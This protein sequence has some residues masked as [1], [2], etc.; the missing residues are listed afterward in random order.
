MDSDDAITNIH[1]ALHSVNSRFRQVFGPKLHKKINC[2]YVLNNSVAVIE[3]PPTT[4]TKVAQRVPQSL[5]G[6]VFNLYLVQQAKYWNNEP[7]Y[8]LDE[9]SAYLAGT[10]GALQLN[11]KDRFQGSFEQSLEFFGYS[12]CL[13]ETV[14]NLPNYD[15]TFLLAFIKWQGERCSR[16]YQEGKRRGWINLKHY[17]PYSA[18]QTSGD[19]TTLKTYLLN[20]FG[21]VWCLQ[22]LGIRP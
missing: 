10:D 9:Y 15:N 2:F 18:L 4:L 11:I 12:L 13:A 17:Q 1:E 5:R 14:N 8:I 6:R 3:E 7:L 22:N 20:V 21:K 19:A 16:I